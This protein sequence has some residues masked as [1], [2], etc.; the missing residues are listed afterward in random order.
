MS[1]AVGGNNGFEVKRKFVVLDNAITDPLLFIYLF[2][3]D[4][5]VRTLKLTS[6]CK[7]QSLISVYSLSR[8]TLC[9]TSQHHESQKENHYKFQSCRP[10]SGYKTPVRDAQ[11]KGATQTCGRYEGGQCRRISGKVEGGRHLIGVVSEQ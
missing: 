5:T 2:L 3:L 9:F 4:S 10:R 8:T 1:L 11:R 7:L 6:I